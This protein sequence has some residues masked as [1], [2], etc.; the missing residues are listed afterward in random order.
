MML[1]A[2]PEDTGSRADPE[3]DHPAW[4]RRVDQQA[5]YSRKSSAAQRAVTRLKVVELVIAAAVPVVAA[6]SGPPL[7]TAGL[8]AVVV[9]L[10]GM[11]QLYQWQTNWVLYRSTAEA[12]KR[13]QFLFLSR[14]GPYA[15]ADRL[16]L[17][18]ERVE[19]LVF[20]EHARWTQGREPAESEHRPAS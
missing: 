10:E 19:G 3:V 20:Q 18:A 6:A 2:G 5:W 15:S 14:A 16:R 11:Q 9:V 4:A 1:M 7:L 17:L 13:E 12:L 8:A